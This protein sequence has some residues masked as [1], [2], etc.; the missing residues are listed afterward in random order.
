MEKEYVEYDESLGLQEI[1]FNIPC[2][3]YY[4]TDES[5]NVNKKLFRFRGV[6]EDLRRKNSS[7]NNLPNMVCAPL[8]QQAFRWFRK[9]YNYDIVVSGSYNLGKK[10]YYRIETPPTIGFQAFEEDFNTYEEAELAC[11][12]KLIEV[13][14]Q[15]N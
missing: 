12:R 10:Y 6:E 8:Y 15:K 14:K 3:A 11:L 9:N 4:I 13:V 5:I 2:F 7:F 1:G